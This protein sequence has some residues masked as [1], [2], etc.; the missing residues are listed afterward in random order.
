MTKA[1]EATEGAIKTHWQLLNEDLL[2]MAREGG[3]QGG[4]RG[5]FIADIA[6]ATLVGPLGEVTT[7][8]RGRSFVLPLG[9]ISSRGVPYWTSYLEEWVLI[10]RSRYRFRAA[11]LT[12]FLG[13]Q[14]EARKAQLF[15]A[16]WPGYADWGGG[17]VTWQAAGAG[18]PHWQFD[19]LQAYVSEETR[20][21][22]VTR[23]LNVLGVGGLEEFGSEDATVISSLA[24]E[25]HDDIGWTQMHF[26]SL[27]QWAVDPWRGDIASVAS[28]SHAPADVAEIR[29]WVT[30][31][32][33]YARHE[34]G[35]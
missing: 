10:E 18:H 21:A 29:R 6:T 17:E 22:D 24:F 8:E 33:Y 35:R 34:L 4:V 31:V 13:R 23:M 15:R 1:L 26:A 16:E 28:H 20:Q 19:A 14:G 30:S 12:F 2:D 32:M 5:E 11:N 7:R 25:D 27:A 3:P 9:P